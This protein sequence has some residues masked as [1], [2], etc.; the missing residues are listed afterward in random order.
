M[1]IF[2]GVSR[3]FQNRRS[4]R[5]PRPVERVELHVTQACNLTCESCSHYSNQGHRGNLDLEQ[6]DR[7][8]GAWSDRIAVKQFNL[9][10]GEPTIH[11]RLSEFVVLVRRHWPTA[12][13]RIVTNGFFLYRHPDLP[14][15]LA[16]DGNADL[17]LSVHHDG[18]HYIRRLR[19][20]LDLVS[21]W[22]WDYGATIHVWESDQNWTRRYIGSGAAMLPFADGRPR[23]SWEICPAKHAIQ[24]HDG[25]L[26]KC[27]PLTYLGMQKKKYDLSEKWDPYLRYKP[28]DRTCTDSAL[29][30]FFALEDEPFC[31]MCPAERHRFPL[32]NPLSKAGRTSTAGRASRAPADNLPC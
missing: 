32:P 30:Q 22:R 16:A 20:I 3:V 11:P 21:T 24:L 7:W 4:K 25:K 14:V 26:W 18:E 28:L 17:A 12:H 15:T 23:Q 10:G 19:P 1:S 8:M 13:I 31:S 2:A 27:A 5:E 6:A 29:D 9:L